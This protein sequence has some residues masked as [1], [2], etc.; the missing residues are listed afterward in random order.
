VLTRSWSGTCTTTTT[1]PT[2]HTMD[3]HRRRRRPLQSTTF[4]PRPPRR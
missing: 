3:N 4:W 1:D 2:A